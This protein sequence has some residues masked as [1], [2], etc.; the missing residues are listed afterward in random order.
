LLA[1]RGIA[2]LFLAGALIG[3]GSIAAAAHTGSAAAAKKRPKHLSLTVQ[4]KRDA[5]APYTFTSSGTLT[6]PGCSGSAYYCI[7]KSKI[8]KGQVWVRIKAGHRTVSLHKV[9]LGKR[10]HYRSTARFFRKHRRLRVRA[11]FKGNSALKSKA[12][13]TVTV[14]AG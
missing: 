8:C 9:K 5:T 7:P 2:S 6:R 10:C 3:S 11:T 13:R 4:P 14:R 12:S 1:H